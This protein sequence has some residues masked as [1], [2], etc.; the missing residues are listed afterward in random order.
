MRRVVGE[1]RGRLEDVL[2]GMLEN[3]QEVR[4]WR[5]EMRGEWHRREEARK[6][7]QK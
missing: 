1:I 5:E 7:R 3:A 2:E 4:N 6:K